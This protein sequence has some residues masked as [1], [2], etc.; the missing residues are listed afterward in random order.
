M[1]HM[2]YLPFLAKLNKVC[3]KVVWVNEVERMVPMNLKDKGT[4][5]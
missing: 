5:R 1:D 3:R 4:R 2:G